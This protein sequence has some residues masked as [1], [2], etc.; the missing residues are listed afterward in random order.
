[1]PSTEDYLNFPR[2]QIGMGSG[3]LQQCTNAKFS[4]KN[5]AKG[6]GTIARPQAGFVMGEPSLEGTLEFD[7]DENGLERDLLADVKA[8]TRKPFRF[9]DS[10]AT[11]EI[12]GVLTSFDLE[13]PK[14]DCVHVGVSYIGKLK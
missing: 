8:G 7:I 5:N 3:N 2:G 6:K 1:M 11:Y 4:Y 9:K 10:T 14:D 13:V 12:I